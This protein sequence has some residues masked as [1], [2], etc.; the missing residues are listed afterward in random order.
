MLNTD[1]LK[2]DTII[3]HG[4]KLYSR[5]RIFIQEQ[6]YTA[7]NTFLDNNDAGIEVSDLVQKEL[8]E[9][10]KITNYSPKFAPHIDLNDALMA[11]FK[12]NFTSTYSNPPQP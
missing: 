1:K 7:I 9:K 10:L 6:G 12:P 11:G 3:L 5:A 2:G 4:L 8:G